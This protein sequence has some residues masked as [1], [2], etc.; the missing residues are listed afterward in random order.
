VVPHP[1]F[2]RDGENIRSDVKVPV[3]TALL[4]GKVDVPTVNGIV[5]LTVPA[6]T[7][8]DTTL[9]IRGQGVPSKSG[10]GDHLVRVVIVVPK[11][12]SLEAADSIRQHLG[13]EVSVS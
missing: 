8:S 3:V 9:R 5:S 4:G 11:E 12:I 13:D 10:G 7:S 2:K 1:Q 6:A